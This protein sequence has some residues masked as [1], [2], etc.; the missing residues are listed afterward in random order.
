VTDP[1]ET[2]RP[3]QVDVSGV[4]TRDDVTGVLHA[5]VNDFRKN[6]DAWENTTLDSFLDG[7]ATAMEDL[8][9]VYAD[10]GEVLPSQ[11]SWQLV[12]ELL[13]TASGYE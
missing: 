3:A 11:P 1:Y 10:R 9:Q 4:T 5:M 13:V 8:E 2:G 6:P 7:L 12:A